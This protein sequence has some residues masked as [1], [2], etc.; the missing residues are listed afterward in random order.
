MVSERVTLPHVYAR[1]RMDSHHARPRSISYGVRT[2]RPGTT[3]GGNLCFV[4]EASREQQPHSY[5]D[6]LHGAT[7]LNFNSHDRAALLRRPILRKVEAWVMVEC[8]MDTWVDGYAIGRT[9]E[10]KRRNLAADTCPGFVSDGLGRVTW[11]NAAFRQTV[12]QGEPGVDVAVCLV[13]KDQGVPVTVGLLAQAAA[14]TCRVRMQ[15]ACGKEKAGSS[16]TLP[17]DVWR[18]DGG[19]FAWRLDVKAALSLGR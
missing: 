9:D 2:A 11:T 1:M 10:E 19:G 12:G 6:Q 13:M 16:L 3:F 4:P 17:C 7:W 18:M 14:F 5:P 8:V 15:Y